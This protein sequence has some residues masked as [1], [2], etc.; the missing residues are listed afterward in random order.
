MTGQ[1]AMIC[2][3]PIK[4]HGREELASV[5][6]EAGACLPDDRRWAVAHEAAKLTP[7]WNPCANFHRGAK[8]PALMAIT[9]QLVGDAVTLRHPD[10]RDLTFRPDNP[11]DLPAFLEWIAPLSP[12]DRTKPTHIVSADVGMTDSP[13][14]SISILSNASLRALSNRMGTELSPHRF[15]GNLWLEGFAPFEEF[16][17]I[18]RRLQIGQAVLEIRERITRCRATMTNPASGR[19]DANT[20]D[21]LASG[22][23]HKDF[24]VYAVATKGGSVSLHDTVSLQ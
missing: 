14:P 13:F 10:L 22:F 17:W 24:G 9:A 15:R 5:L 7:G 20:L 21:A 23:G 18:G 4:A 3:H 19:I 1:V 8:A 2:R 16:N 11:D 6:L 12:P